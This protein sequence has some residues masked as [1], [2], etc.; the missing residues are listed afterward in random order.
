MAQDAVRA[1]LLPLGTFEAAWTARVTRVREAFLATLSEAEQVKAT[2]FL[3]AAAAAADEQW[4]AAKAGRGGPGRKPPGRT[5]P[6]PG[7]TS[8]PQTQ[9]QTQWTLRPTAA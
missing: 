7:W 4:L 8:W 1:G 6:T 3:Q 2:R 5:P 9:L